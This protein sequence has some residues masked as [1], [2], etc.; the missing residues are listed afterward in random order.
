[1]TFSSI[2]TTFITIM[3]VFNILQFQAKRKNIP[4]C[5]NISL[6]KNTTETDGLVDS[7]SYT[8]ATPYQFTAS[9]HVA[10][11]F[12]HMLHFKFK[13][14]VSKGCSFIH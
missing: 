2:I 3:Y 5:K 12:L 4:Q 9:R 13:V 14:T 8:L 1:M 6:S 11:N 10:L 7:L